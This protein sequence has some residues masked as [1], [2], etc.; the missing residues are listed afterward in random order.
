VRH[1]VDTLKL[2]RSSSHRR[3]LLANLVSSLILEDKIET[4]EVKAKAAARMADKMVTLAKKNTLAARRQAVSILRR[5]DAV[6]K[7]FDE[8]GPRFAERNG[9]YTRVLKLAAF[10]RGDGA[11]TAL[12]LFSEDGSAPPAK[13]GKTAG[14]SR[15]AAPAAKASTGKSATKAAAS[16]PK[17]A[18]S[19]ETP[20]PARTRKKKS[21][22]DPEKAEKKSA[23]D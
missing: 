13:G 18:P 17:K 22:T 9:G 4:T 23:E 19:A 10:R 16:S 8:I 12:V 3:A 5:K 15:Q 2:N 1:R 14:R 21:E 20:K 7:L 11:R 6:K